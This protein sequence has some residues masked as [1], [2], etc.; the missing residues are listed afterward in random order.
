MLLWP[1]LP[2]RPVAAVERRQSVSLSFVAA[3]PSPVSAPSETIAPVPESAVPNNELIPTPTPTQPLPDAPKTPPPESEPVVAAETSTTSVIEPQS[4][5]TDDISVVEQSNA[6]ENTSQLPTEPEP[7]E[8]VTSTPEPPKQAETAVRIDES[9]TGRQPAPREESADEEGESVS[10]IAV[11]PDASVIPATLMPARFAGPTPTIETPT[12]AVRRRLRGTV[13]LRG[14]VDPQGT[15][16]E[17]SILESSGHEVL[18]D[19]A[20]TQAVEWRFQPARSGTGATGEWV[21]IPVTFR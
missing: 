15:L 16:S 19:A 13:V 1:A 2:S 8:P 14:F 20:Q 5:D 11:P 18:D 9:E 4:D 17:I 3:Q 21:R 6:S 10:D 7:A 12:E